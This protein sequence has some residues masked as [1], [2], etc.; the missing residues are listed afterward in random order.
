MQSLPFALRLPE[1]PSTSTARISTE[2]HSPKLTRAR[3]LTQQYGENFKITTDGD[4]V[5]K[6][7]LKFHL[8]GQQ[9]IE[10]N[11]RLE[12][13]KHIV[14]PDTSGPGATWSS[15]N[16]N[17]RMVEVFLTLDM[18]TMSRGTRHIPPFD[19]KNHDRETKTFTRIPDGTNYAAYDRKMNLLTVMFANPYDLV[20][21][22]NEGA[23]IVRTAAKNIDF[24]ITYALP[25]PPPK[26]DGRYQAF[27]TWVD[28]PDNAHFAGGYHGRSGLWHFGMWNE[29]GNPYRGPVLTK[30]SVAGASGARRQGMMQD[31]MHSF[32]DITRTINF[33][34]EAVAPKLR[35]E[36][37]VKY[38]QIPHEGPKKQ[39]QTLP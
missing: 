11:R 14:H 3:S 6:L 30:D 37:Y 22:K 25:P 36:Y 32:G 23:K 15:G 39:A 26:D 24:S 10:L 12:E 13:T 4:V 29:Q 38:G 16:M 9:K 34:F 21:G 20:W 1:F 31:L 8:T 5:E 18:A 7:R 27:Q 35:A 19:Q 33:C 2:H 28:D 17:G